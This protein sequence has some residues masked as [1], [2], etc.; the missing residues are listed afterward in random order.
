MQLIYIEISQQ[1][2]IAG[3]SLAGV[4]VGEQRG[5]GGGEYNIAF[6]L[7]LFA[8]HGGKVEKQQTAW[9]SSW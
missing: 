2:P 5:R 4:R 6:L 1:G 7:W 3:R 9:R 8:T